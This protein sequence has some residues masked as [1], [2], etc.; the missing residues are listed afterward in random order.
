MSVAD[1][2][3]QVQILTKQSGLKYT[4]HSAGTTV[5]GPWDEVYTLIG[6]WHEK[7]HEMGVHRVQSSIRTGTRTDKVQTAQDKL[8]TVN[9]K[10]SELGQ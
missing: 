10:L 8:D 3:V 2:I 1:Y 7:V 6:K 4:L 9:R 5:E